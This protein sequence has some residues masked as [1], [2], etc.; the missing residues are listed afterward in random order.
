MARLRVLFASIAII[1]AHITFL[2]YAHWGRSYAVILLI[3]LLLFFLYR[4][5]WF[6]MLAI[7]GGL[8]SLT[9]I[10]FNI[11]SL[12]FDQIFAYI[13]LLLPLIIAALFYV[14][15]RDNMLW[16]TI[17]FGALLYYCC[18]IGINLFISNNISY[19]ES[20]VAQSLL[21][22]QDFWQYGLKRFYQDSGWKTLLV[23][24]NFCLPFILF[25]L[26]NRKSG[27]KFSYFALVAFLIFCLFI[28]ANSLIFCLSLLLLPY[29]LD[30]KALFI[31]TVIATFVWQFT[32]IGSIYLCYTKVFC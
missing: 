18:L 20:D 11:F 25:I 7:C 1:T 3:E 16:C 6:R 14:S 4:E 15:R 2:S 12:Q 23:V 30:S 17:G 9:S 21:N 26:I 10:R 5:N 28:D 22:R 29:W 24:L 31:F 32:I 27:T 19:L 13:N 8:F